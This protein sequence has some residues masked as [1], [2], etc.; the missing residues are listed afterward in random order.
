MRLLATVFLSFILLSCDQ[1][2]QIAKETGSIY[3]PP[4]RQEISD[5]IREALTVGIK[6]AVFQTAQENGFYN[7]PSIKIP[8]PP[9]ATKV[10]QTVRDLGLGG[11][12]D[13]FVETLNH[14]AEEAA[15]KATPIFVDAIKQ[16]TIQDVYDIWKGEKDAATQ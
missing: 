14:G 16:M 5:G 4:T 7:N 10:E 8:F 11:Q 12:V 3:A 2:Q 1:L 13:K 15:E 6:N 9:E